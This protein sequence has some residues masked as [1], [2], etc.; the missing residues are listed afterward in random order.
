MRYNQQHEGSLLV[1]TICLSAVSVR[2]K[3]K[4][5]QNNK[6]TKELNTPVLVEPNTV[7]PS[8]LLEEQKGKSPTGITVDANP[9]NERMAFVV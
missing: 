8:F 6:K 2:Q 9:S 5:H 4:K 7:P 3:E 1:V